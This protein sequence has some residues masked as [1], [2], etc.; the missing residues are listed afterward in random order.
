MEKRQ[1]ESLLPG[2]IETWLEDLGEKK[3]R[4]GQIFTW[5]GRGVES[6]AE[7]T[8]ISKDLREQLE[9]NFVLVNL[10]CLNKQVSQ[11]DGTVKYLWAYEDDNSVETVLLHQ[12]YGN[13]LCISTQI[14]CRM[15]CTFCASALGGFVRNLTAAEIL[16][17]IKAVQKDA[18]VAISNIVFMGMGEPLDNFEAVLR[19]LTLVNHPAGRNIGMRHITLSTSGL[20]EKIDKLSTYHL[21]LNLA[22]S[23]H[24][25]DDETRSQ[26]MPV[27]RAGGIAPLLEACKRYF[28]QTGRRVSFEYAMIQG[29]NDSPK[30]ARNLA[31]HMLA[32][33]GHVNLIPLN[34]VKE[35]SH[36]A[37]EKSRL[38]SFYKILQ[39]KGVT[40]TI[41]QRKG[42]DI[43]A[44]CGQLR[45]KQ[46]QA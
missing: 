15:G 34:A 5:L 24:A 43:D 14:G 28:G 25:A 29:L 9:K 21:Q 26:I 8:N 33:G 7:M 27:N 20:I 45:R 35:R 16:A 19:F 38:D 4:A 32:V 3:F 37:S 42:Q 12:D 22:V 46:T 17:Q 30:D 1:I 13:T 2:E 31:K 44:A 40:V 39:E 18:K 36:Q 41:R 6:F 11:I 10:Q 23:L